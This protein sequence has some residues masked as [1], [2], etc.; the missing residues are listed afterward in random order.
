M[1]VKPSQPHPHAV[2]ALTRG[3][4]LLKLLSG[5]APPGPTA[6]ELQRRSGI[7]PASFFRILR[8]LQDA[9]LIAQEPRSGCYQLGAG[10][11]L[12]GFTARAHSPLVLAAQPILRDLSAA[13]HQMAELAVAT[14]NWTLMILETWLA[15]RSSLNIRARPGLFFPLNHLHAPGLCYLSFDQDFGLTRYQRTAARA[16]G[17]AQLGLTQPIAA[18]LPGECERW[19]RL[20]Y[21][22]RPQPANAT[23]RVTAPI[24]STLHPGEVVGALSIV[25]ARAELTPVRIVEWGRVL[26]VGAERIV[27]NA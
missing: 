12:L 4:E 27:L 5:S 10:A 23:A 20:G 21:C 14:G 26:K 13:T 24:Y 8:V 7:P 17:V 2:P 6:A 25:C 9:R 18:S 15:E 11:M 22:Y 19:R 16:G 1:I 3:L